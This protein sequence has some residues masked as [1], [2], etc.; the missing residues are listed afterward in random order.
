MRREHATQNHSAAWPHWGL[1]SAGILLSLWAALWFFLI[2]FRR[3]IATVSATE[4][5][6][7]IPF[8]FVYTGLFI[9]AHDSMHQSLVPRNP[10]LNDRLGAL[11]VGIFALFSYQKLLKNHRLHHQH[12]VSQR[13]PDFSA[14]RLGWVGWFWAFFSHYVTP[15]QFIALSLI[16]QALHSWGGVSWERLIAFQILPPVLATFQLF[17]FGTY[18]PHRRRETSPY[19]DHHHARTNDYPVWL[20]FLTCYHFG[21]HHEHHLEPSVPWYRLPQRRKK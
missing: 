16:S 12:P 2:A 4:W 6:L 9:T 14:S 5:A 13:D 17:H 20:S 8:A 11:C 3:D 18:L 21:Y 1:L 15:L 10:R 19:P 7:V